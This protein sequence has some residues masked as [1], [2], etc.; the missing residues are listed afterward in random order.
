MFDFELEIVD[1]SAKESLVQKYGLIIPVVLDIESN[2]LLYW[3][4]DRDDVIN[5]LDG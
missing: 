3:P 2:D 1:I 4:F 5:L